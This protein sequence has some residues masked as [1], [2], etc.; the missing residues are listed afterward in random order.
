MPRNLLAA[1]L[2]AVAFWVPAA[3]AADDTAGVFVGEWH[4]NKAESSVVPGEPLP[5]EVVLRIASATPARIQWTLT[6]TDADG[7]QHTES[8][9]GS[10]GGQPGPITGAPDTT[11][12]FTLKATVLEAS[13][14]SK[15]GSTDRTSCTLSSDRRKMTCN[16]TESDG[17]GHSM[18][19]VDVYDRR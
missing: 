16:G 19:Y 18:N 3:S 5:R 4:W 2:V 17:K 13:Y 11:G 10:G 15:D 8:F 9:L 6:R 1:F 7:R 14:Q 12:A